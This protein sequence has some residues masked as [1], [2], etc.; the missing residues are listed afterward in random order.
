MVVPKTHH[1]K[2]S[3]HVNTEEKH[4]PAKAKRAFPTSHDIKQQHKAR[5]GRA[6]RLA[7]N[8]QLIYTK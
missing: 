7:N 8:Q 5:K 4:S 2:H 6:E 1:S 3:M